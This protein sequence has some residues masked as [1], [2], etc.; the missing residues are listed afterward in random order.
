MNKITAEEALE[1][2]RNNI[3]KAYTYACYNKS[4]KQNTSVLEE[5]THRMVDFLFE[6]L[7]TPTLDEVVKAWEDCDYSEGYH[8]YQEGN[9]LRVYSGNELYFE[10]DARSLEWCWYGVWIDQLTHY[11]IN[12][13]IKYL[14]SYKEEVK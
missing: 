5:Q 2:I 14:E 13:T 10:A 3:T 4:T 6:Q 11:A 7:K 9:I 12:L 1:I 8:I